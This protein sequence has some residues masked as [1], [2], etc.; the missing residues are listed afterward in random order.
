V[1]FPD[2]ARVERRR[3]FSRRITFRGVYNERPDFTFMRQLQIAQLHHD[4][5]QEDADRQILN[6]EVLS[7]VPLAHSS[8]GRQNLLM[9]VAEG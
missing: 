5:E 4:Q 7:E 8:Q 3:N 9:G 2:F 1:G 6:Q